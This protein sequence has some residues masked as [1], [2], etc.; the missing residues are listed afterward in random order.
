M[1]KWWSPCRLAQQQIVINDANSNSNAKLCLIGFEKKDYFSKKAIFLVCR[2][3]NAIIIRAEWW[4]L[5]LFC[6]IMRKLVGNREYEMCN[7][8]RKSDDVWIGFKKRAHV[9]TLLA[10]A[11]G[12]SLIFRNVHMPCLNE[13]CNFK[14]F[15]PHLSRYAFM[16]WKG[17][18][19]IWIIREKAASI[20][21]KRN[22][23]TVRHS[24]AILHAISHRLMV[25]AIKQPIKLSF[26]FSFCIYMHLQQQP[27][28]KKELFQFSLSARARCIAANRTYTTKPKLMNAKAH[29]KL[30][31]NHEK[32]NAA[33]AAS[34]TNSACISKT[35]T[36]TRER[37]RYKEIEFSNRNWARLKM[38]AGNENMLN[39][40]DNCRYLLRTKMKKRSDRESTLRMVFLSLVW[41]DGIFTHFEIACLRRAA[42][43]DCK[44]ITLSYISSPTSEEIKSRIVM[45]WS[46]VH[47][48]YH[49]LIFALFGS[50]SHMLHTH[51]I[52][53]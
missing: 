30:K 27:R 49:L 53:E 48:K 33:N 3:R 52:H 21:V 5:E 36:Y 44:H 17:V 31:R 26:T 2:D 6:F 13:R 28:K 9:R 11:M 51:Q 23:H 14:A 18:N 35:G 45:G 1:R 38:S 22:A 7:V 16:V 43:W 46:N 37:P 4:N 24:Y 41:I 15:R 29:N 25:D 34:H 10:Y 8:N 32:I 39:A 19:C 40:Q 12:S 20:S 50:K 47:M 42:F